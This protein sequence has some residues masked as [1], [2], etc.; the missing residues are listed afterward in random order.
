MVADITSPI[1]QY[2][3]EGLSGDQSWTLLKRMAFEEEQQ[4][5]NSNLK[6]IGMDI[7]KKCK[8]VPL[9]IKTIGRVLNY[10]KIEV[11]WS[12]IK[13]SE[14]TNVTQLKDDIMLVLKL[15]YEHLPS[16]LKCCFAYCSLFPKDYLIVKLTLIQLWIAQGFIQSPDENL[17]LVDVADDY[18]KELLWRSFFQEVEE[19]EGM[20]RSF[21]MHDLIHD[22]AQYV[23]RID[24][25]LVDSNAKKCE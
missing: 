25:T 8:G 9:A 20:T 7:V 14:L 24:C 13:D 6:A 22:L 19:D 11:E 16:H 17:L 5:I 18:F 10:K 2:P 15:S 12:Y 1:S 21:K 23:S 3:L 4:T